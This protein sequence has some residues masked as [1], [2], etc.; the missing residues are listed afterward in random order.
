MRSVASRRHKMRGHSETRVVRRT[1]T[2]LDATDSA[3]SCAVVWN[4]RPTDLRLSS[5]TAPT[6]AEHLKASLFLTRISASEDYLFCALQMH[7][8]LRDP[9]SSR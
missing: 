9:L 3:V 6:F 5:L 2:V 8:L 4:S 1:Q 7:A